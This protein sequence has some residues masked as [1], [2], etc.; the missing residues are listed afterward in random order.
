VGRE[1]TSLEARTL[2]HSLVVV[3]RHGRGHAD[4]VRRLPPAHTIKPSLE[5]KEDVS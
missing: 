4:H 5:D 3:G 1:E 2:K